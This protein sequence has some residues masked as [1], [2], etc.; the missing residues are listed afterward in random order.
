MALLYRSLLLRPIF[1]E[2]ALSSVQQVHVSVL[3]QRRNL[4]VHPTKQSSME[5]SSKY[6][7]EPVK[8]VFDLVCREGL[9]SDN[10]ERDKKVVEFVQPAELGERLGG[11]C[12]EKEGIE[13]VDSL[14]EA[15][16]KYRQ[17]LI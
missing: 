14:I 13:D 11:L 16:A 15:V 12:I 4:T 8:K 10:Y 3:Q 7:I 9:I 1:T 5:N 2:K 17:P 6:N